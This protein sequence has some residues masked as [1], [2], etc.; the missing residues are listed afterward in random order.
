M[1]WFL[2]DIV[3]RHE[4]VKDFTSKHLL[5][6][7]IC[8]HEICVKFVYKHSQ[9][10]EKIKINLLFKRD[11]ETSRSN[12]ARILRIKKANFSGLLLFI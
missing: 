8:A 7:E 9:T 3:L 12:N 10:I 11:L 1:D 5:R 4:R 2:N 6:F